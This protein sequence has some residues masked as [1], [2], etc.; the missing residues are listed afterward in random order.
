MAKT[1]SATSSSALAE[2]KTVLASL[3]LALLLAGCVSST[4]RETRPTLNVPFIAQESNYCGPAALAMLANFY[5]YSVSQDEI[6]GSIYLP[7]IHGTLTSDLADY[8][9][10]FN[11]WVRS[12]RGSTVD[13]REKIRAGVPMIVLGK[14]GANFHFF[15]VLGFDDFNET[16]MVHSDS[17][18]R[19]ELNQDD[20]FR[21]WDR[22]G[23]WTLLVCPPDRT[24]WPLSAEENNDLG[25]F[26]EQ[27]GRLVAAAGHYQS[28]MDLSPANSYF[29]MNLGN[30]LLKQNLFAEAASA[31]AGAVK[32]DP[33]NADALNNLAY[34]YEELGAN[35]DQAIELCRR[36]AALRPSHRAYYLDTM[37]AV[38]LKQERPK[39]A[40]AVFE[41]ALAATTD[42][43]SSLR[44]TIAQHLAA[45]RTQLKD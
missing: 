43:Q 15:V 13:L 23:R 30:A 36:A 9:R 18:A 32:V 19:L 4:P 42:R 38:Y 40:V 27:T 31:Y 11:L 16:V 37:G 14:F 3:F 1:R 25:V 17:R 41:S 8:A 26:L 22:A 12:Y 39:D 34:A 44:A 5:G 10:R 28:A 7:D 21:F 24:P 6:A 33:E 2:L 29:R 20:F 45:A 35:L